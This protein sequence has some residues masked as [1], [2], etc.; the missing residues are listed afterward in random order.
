MLEILTL[1]GIFAHHVPGAAGV[2]AQGGILM[3]R[4]LL[5]GVS[6]VLCLLAPILFADPPMVT[7]ADWLEDLPVALSG[8]RLAQTAL[9][10]PGAIAVIDRAMIEVS[11]VRE[12]H[13]L[14]RLVPGML[15]HNDNGHHAITSYRAL[16]DPY[17]RRI[18]VLIDGRAAYSPVISSVNWAMLPLT[19][20]DI[21][22]IEVFRGP[23]AATYGANA[24]LGVISITTRLPHVAK[25]AS[26]TLSR[27]NNGIYRAQGIV[28]GQI[29]DFDWRVTVQALGD[30]GLNGPFLDNDDKHP[31]LISG[32]ANWLDDR[33]GLWGVHVG[34]AR[35]RL[36]HGGTNSPLRPP[37]YIYSRNGYAQLDWR[38]QDNL[39]D[40]HNFK[41]FW[42]LD[43]WSQDYLTTPLPQ[44]G[45]LQGRWHLSV[46]GERG[47]FEYS[48][49]IQP[50]DGL[51]SV[52]GAAAR[53]DRMQAPG[54]LGT[55]DT[56]EKTL[57]RAFTHHE[58][59]I[60]SQLVANLGLMVEH[61]SNAGTEVAP[62]AA[63]SWSYAPGQV[64]RL[65]YG[66]ATRTPTIVE[67]SANHVLDFGPVQDQL[68]LSSGGL[69][70]ERIRSREI[71]WLLQSPSLNLTLDTRISWDRID[72]LITYYFTPFP[73]LD[74]QVQDF[75]NFDAMT[76]RGFETQA[77]WRPVQRARVV[78][79]YSLADISATDVDELY[80]ASGPRHVWSVFGEYQFENLTTVSLIWYRIGAMQGLNT[81]NFAKR[82]ERAD[83]KISRLFHIGDRPARVS[84]TL[85]EPIGDLRDFRTRNEF[86]RRWFVD[87]AY[88]F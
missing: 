53:L 1:G 2:H 21:E 34:F 66:T 9:D 26:V 24:F 36:E 12:V 73:D 27:G 80:S 47:E 17:P 61:D 86:H 23:N 8:S 65:S 49:V 68:L 33:G 78:L 43:S 5:A 70:S 42:T 18:L 44:L 85:Q 58:W 87:V 75:R 10:A 14:L 63:L 67:E 64:V 52:W 30:D 62:R 28:G 54:Y 13:E 35:A 45:G 25:G 19:L 76:I 40:H 74:G 37:H 56:L 59:R 60:S 57:Y 55:P 31:K 3:R 29:D 69:R 50:R 46:R 79:N 4:L 82:T 51:R 38:S 6:S 7:E 72:R 88:R 77:T 71:G 39:D 16:S 84:F 15:V 11:G 81:G 41:A 48:R 22:R 83:I 32:R 20:E